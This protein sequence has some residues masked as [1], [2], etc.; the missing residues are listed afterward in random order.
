LEIIHKM[1]ALAGAM[2]APKWAAEAKSFCTLLGHTSSVN[3][4]KLRYCPSHGPIFLLPRQAFFSPP[5][6]SSLW[7]ETQQMGGKQAA[8]VA[9]VNLHQARGR[10]CRPARMSRGTGRN[11]SPPNMSS[12]PLQCVPVAEGCGL[13]VTDHPATLR[14]VPVAEGC[15]YT[16]L[17]TDW[18]MSAT[19][20]FSSRAAVTR[21][22]DAG[23]SRYVSP[24]DASKSS[25]E[26][27]E[28][29]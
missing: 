9:K 28:T 2:A 11:P 3:A 24:E 12:P 10:M 26:F 6:L 13:G 27:T 22:F 16:L 4:L 17:P 25:K 7:G 8:C 18:V 19:R 23:T 29:H 15:G 1:A 5:P 14:C 21:R 20:V